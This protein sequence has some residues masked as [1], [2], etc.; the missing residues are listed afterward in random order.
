MVDVLLQNMVM[1][2]L[3]V[4]FSAIEHFVDFEVLTAAVVNVV[5]FWD[6][7]RACTVHV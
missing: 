3:N 5:I 2:I 7:D 4:P 6:I 1:Y